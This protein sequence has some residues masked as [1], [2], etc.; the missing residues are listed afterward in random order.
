[1]G[2]LLISS[3]TSSEVDTGSVGVLFGVD[4]WKEAVMVWCGVGAVLVIT[5]WGSGGVLLTLLGFGGAV[6]LSCI[7]GVSRGLSADFCHIDP[8]FRV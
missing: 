1:M 8:E 3:S 5:Q 2:G 6:V 4:L 7:C